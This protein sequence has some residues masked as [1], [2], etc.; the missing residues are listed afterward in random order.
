MRRRP[1]ARETQLAPTLHVLRCL[2]L[3]LRHLRHVRRLSGEQRVEARTDRPTVQRSISGPASSPRA[4]RLRPV[5]EG[6]TADGGAPHGT[7]AHPLPHL[8]GLR[9][10]PRRLPPVHRLPH[11]GLDAVRVCQKDPL[12]C[13]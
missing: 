2:L 11:G 12:C 8:H 5:F 13:W 1:C 4:K 7:S 3:P 9:H 10:R 6:P